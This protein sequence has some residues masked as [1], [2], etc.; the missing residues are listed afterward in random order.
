MTVQPKLLRVLQSGEIQRVGS[1]ENIKVNVRIVTATNRDLAE[2]VRT[3][4]FRADLYHRITIYPVQV[5]ALRQRG[6]DILLLAGNALERNR[7]SLHLRGLRLASASQQALLSAHWPGNVRELEHTIS[8]A[9]LKAAAG[10]SG[11]D[12]IVTIEPSH[13]DLAKPRLDEAAQP[14]R[15]DE[16]MNAEHLSLAA[17]S[18][19]FQRELIERTLLTQRGN[20]AAAARELE[21]DRG[22]LRRLAKRL[23]IA[24]S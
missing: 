5:P 7:A 19:K 9:A 16:P 6:R 15:Q 20:W 13:L 4:R 1:D 18:A 12:R 2:E 21:L 14:L 8:R 11:S 17:A 3:G 24:G 22:N 23:G 10:G